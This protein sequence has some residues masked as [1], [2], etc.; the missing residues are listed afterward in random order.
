MMLATR[1]LPAP[2]GVEILAFDL[3]QA[4]KDRHYSA[5]RAL[6]EEHSL[7]LFRN[8]KIDDHTHTKIA[9][10]FGT[11]ENREAMAK[12]VPHDFQVSLVSNDDGTGTAIPDDAMHLLDL[13]ANMLWH[14]DST[15]LPVPALA[16]LLLARTLP[17]HG[18]ETEFASS[19]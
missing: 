14:T 15:F 7:L 2:F 16:N 5:I 10:W 13:Q 17:R 18:G 3:T 12:N 9:Q 6:F 11:P 1:S 8:Q 4:S 19:W